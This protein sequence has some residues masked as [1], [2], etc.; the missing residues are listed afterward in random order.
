MKYFQVLAL[1]ATV[2]AL[3]FAPQPLPHND[4]STQQS[5]GEEQFLIEL[6]PGQT[7]WVTEDTKWELKRVR[8]TAELATG[9]R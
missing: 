5:V 4:P 7:K 9:R 6:A 1:A 3:S 8:L 2:S